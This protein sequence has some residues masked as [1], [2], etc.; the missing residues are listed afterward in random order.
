MADG[1]AFDAVHEALGLVLAA[2]MREQV[3]ETPP[4]LGGPFEVVVEFGV[5]LHGKRMKGE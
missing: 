2:G 4:E 3:G 1:V 5:G